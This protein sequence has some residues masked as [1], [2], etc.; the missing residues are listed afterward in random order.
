ML[1][2]DIEERCNREIRAARRVRAVLLREGE[3]DGQHA[4]L[5]SP[6]LRGQLPAAS[7]RAGGLR[8][9]EIEGL[10]VN[11]CGGTHIHSTAELQVRHA[12]SFAIVQPAKYGMETCDAS[13]ESRAASTSTRVQEVGS[14]FT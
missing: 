14:A 4:L 10:D 1:V 8:L 3:A 5:Q 12:L 9:L 2:Q 11:A 13:A 6:L 7:K